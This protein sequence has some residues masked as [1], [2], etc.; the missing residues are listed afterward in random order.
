MTAKNE[1]VNDLAVLTAVFTII[2]PVD[3]AGINGLLYKFCFETLLSAIYNHMLAFHNRVNVF[4]LCCRGKYQGNSTSCCPTNFSC[5][6]PLQVHGG[7]VL[8]RLA[9]P[10]LR[11]YPSRG[12]ALLLSFVVLDVVFY[13]AGQ[14]HVLPALT[15]QARSRREPHFLRFAE[16]QLLSALLAYQ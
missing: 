1:G 8:S 12:R 15:F 3:G 13:A 9:R 5:I 16:E 14:G 10:S 2:D 7:A 11:L 4:D 6:I